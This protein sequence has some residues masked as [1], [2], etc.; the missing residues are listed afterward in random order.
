VSAVIRLRAQGFDI[1][2]TQQQ[3]IAIRPADKLPD[4]W[5]KWIRDNRRQVVNELKAEAAND[6][7]RKRLDERWHWF[8]SL[9]AEHGIH[10]DVVGAEFPTDDDR[11]DVVE[12]IE[13][14]DKTLRACMATLCSDARVLNRQTGLL[15]SSPMAA[16]RY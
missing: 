16:S 2:L 5:C 11:L 10:P 1:R 15:R 3:S 8:L 4:E 12:P 14:D 13:H 9:A 6:G 7:E